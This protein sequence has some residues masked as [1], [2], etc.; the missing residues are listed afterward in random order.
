MKVRA[1][2]VCAVLGL[3]GCQLTPKIDPAWSTAELAAPSENVL[4]AVAGQELQRSGFPVGSDADPS[5]L[6]MRTGW[7][8]H[9]APFRGDGF[10]EQ[11]E[12]RFE[13]VAPERWRVEV[14]V[15]RENNMDMKRPIDPSSAE[16]EA[17][18][19]NSE[20]AAVIL[21]RIRARLGE[22]LDVRAP[23]KGVK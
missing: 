22:K 2:L 3:V 8:T 5:T 20:R 4:W 18:A 9:L 15:L 23:A 7:S 21:Q 10:R 19:D 17:V 12:V 13:S 6:V 16:W 11:A 14:R 1:A